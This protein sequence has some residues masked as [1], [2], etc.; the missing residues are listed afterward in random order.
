MEMIAKAKALT[1]ITWS[2]DSTTLLYVRD[3][4]TIC[5][6]KASGTSPVE[7]GP[8]RE[9]C[10]LGDDR[11]AFVKNHEI[12]SAPANGGEPERLFGH[13]AGFRGTHKGSP[14]ATADGAEM[15]CV[16]RDVTRAAADSGTT[17]MSATTLSPV[18]LS[19]CPTS[20]SPSPPGSTKSKNTSP[21]DIR[22]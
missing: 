8:G 15:L 13:D 16:I 20:V 4:D 7:I 14:R 9:P 18:A 21:A 12:W 1:N 2:F 10:W 22:A 3:H 19:V 11:V 6:Q 17:P 5:A